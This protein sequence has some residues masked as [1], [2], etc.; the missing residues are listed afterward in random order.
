MKTDRKE[1][2]LLS[3]ISEDEHKVFAMHPA[4]DRIVSVYR[5]IGTIKLKPGVALPMGWGREIEKANVDEN[6]L[7]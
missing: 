5:L 4:D 1:K 3:K 2:I 6:N 7:D